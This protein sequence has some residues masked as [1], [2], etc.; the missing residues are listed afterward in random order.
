MSIN[1]ATLQDQEVQLSDGDRVR[2]GDLWAEQ[3]LVLVFLRHYG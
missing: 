3:P 2:F 1:P